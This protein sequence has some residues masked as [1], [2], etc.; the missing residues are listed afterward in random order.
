VCSRAVNLLV[1]PLDSTDLLVK[2]P[3][4]IP[5]LFLVCR[6]LPVELGV[7]PPGGSTTLSFILERSR[8]SLGVS[9]WLPCQLLGLSG[10][11][12]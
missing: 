8:V 1:L 5:E 4:P 9:F 12:V 11:P 6:P 3:S 2:R 7:V 10:L